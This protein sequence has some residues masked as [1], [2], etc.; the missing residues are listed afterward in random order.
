MPDHSGKMSVE[1]GLHDANDLEDSW[2]NM[3]AVD[4]VMLNSS[5]IAGFEEA[6][7]HALDELDGLEANHV[8][9]FE[10]TCYRGQEEDEVVVEMVGSAPF[11]EVDTGEPI[12]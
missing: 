9:N 7:W 10:L 1:F 8:Y 4:G 5:V 12:L 3:T 11:P 6:F 2:I